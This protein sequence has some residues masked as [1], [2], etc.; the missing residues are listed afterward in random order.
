MHALVIAVK[1]Q[2]W[3]LCVCRFAVNDAAIIVLFAG[4]PSHCSA[5][6]TLKRPCVNRLNTALMLRSKGDPSCNK[7]AI[8]L[9]SGGARDQVQG[10]E[11][12]HPAGAGLCEMG[13][14]GTPGVLRSLLSCYSKQT[15]A[16][17][18]CFCNPLHFSSQ[19][20]SRWRRLLHDMQNWGSKKFWLGLLGTQST[21]S[22]RRQQA[23]R[24]LNMRHSRAPLHVAH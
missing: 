4:E 21:L 17:R 22:V 24:N 19:V 3:M 18:A 23:C 12:S 1:T 5:G 20:T 2:S 13:Q 8:V 14:G 16:S 11:G 15:P 9:C 6:C 10:A 7:I